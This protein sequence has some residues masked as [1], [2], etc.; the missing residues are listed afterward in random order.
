MSGFLTSESDTL[1]TV[2]GRGSS[3][4]TNVTLSGTGNH[5]SGHHYFDPWDANGNHYPHYL[6]GSS[7]NGAQV[8]LRVQQS[9]SSNY[10]V[11]YI[12]AGTNT[13]TWRGHTIWNSGND[14]AGT[15]L[16]A[17]K[18]D[19]QHGS[20]YLDYNNFS[21]TPTIPSSA[22]FLSK[23]YSQNWTRLGYGTS[24]SAYWHRLAQVTINGRSGRA[25][26]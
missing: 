10:D 12:A 1:A 16:D 18:L 20:Y 23:T 7:N 5:F 2:T 6:S 25:H 8:N 21:N 14:G 22:D 9:G 13:M 17:D 11:L 24:G 3:T 26:V 15:G 19:G 4:S